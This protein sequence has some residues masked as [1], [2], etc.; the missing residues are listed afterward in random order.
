MVTYDLKDA[1]GRIFAFEI[2]NVL[3]G[4]R[5]TQRVIE[6]IAGVRLIRRDRL[7]SGNDQ[8]CEFELDG[9]R[10]VVWE[11][12][13]DNSRYWIGPVTPGATPQILRVREA[14]VARSSG[15][16]AARIALFAVLFIFWLAYAA[17][18]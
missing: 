1:D 17:T 5:G 2:S 16:A 6:K 13:G 15:V 11:P 14:F 10:F 3:I 12:W 4:R 8:F 9:V 7:F 18:R